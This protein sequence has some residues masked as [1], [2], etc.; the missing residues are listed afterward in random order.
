MRGRWTWRNKYSG[1]LAEL[2]Q[3][4]NALGNANKYL[5]Q[6]RLH[7]YIGVLSAAWKRKVFVLLS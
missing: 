2:K 3:G 4:V 5:S 1:V 6:A 7:E